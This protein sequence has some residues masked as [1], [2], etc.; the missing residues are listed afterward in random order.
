MNAARAWRVLAINPGS[1]S[2]KVGVFE[3]ARPLVV[4]SIRHTAEELS[5]FATIAEQRGYRTQL[6][7]DA[8]A[9]AG[10]PLADLDAFVGRGGGLA[11]MAGG[12]YCVND[13][14]L[15]D[16]RSGRWAKHPATLGAQIAH[17]LATEQHR[18]AFIVNGPDTD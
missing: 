4:T 3:G 8:I 6:V 15:S 14:M 11:P 17:E 5:R 13:V 2:T 1:T 16:T 18:P 7:R 9:E 10:I 12:V